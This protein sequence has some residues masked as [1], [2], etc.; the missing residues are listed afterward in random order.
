[1]T[2]INH[3]KFVNNI[4]FEKEELLIE[5]SKYLWSHP[6]TRFEEYLSSKKLLTVL[7]EEGFQ[8]E[9]NLADIKTAFKGEY[10][11]GKP[12]IGFLG[13]FDALSG[14]S[15][16]ALTDIEQAIDGQTNGHGCGHNRSEE[17]RVG[18][19]WRCQWWRGVDST[20]Q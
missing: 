2:N 5:T 4:I 18:K 14:L 20:R 1:M 8:I 16:K 9:E 17:R 11:Q 15:Q 6:E 7:E 19:E 3:Q 10:G 12:I 13:E